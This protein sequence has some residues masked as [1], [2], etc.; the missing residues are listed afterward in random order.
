MTLLTTA[1]LAAVEAAIAAAESQS[2][3]ELVVAVVG[4]SDRY[5]LPRGLFA[6][7]STL[8]LV[9]VLHGLFPHVPATVLL[10]GQGPW[11]LLSWFVLGRP[12]F[13]RHLAGDA[14]IE[15]TV[16]QRALQMFAAHGVYRTRDQSGLL[17]M[18]SQMERRVIILGDTGI[19]AR[20][21]T[22]GWQGYIEI[23]VAG[24]RRGQTGPALVQVL[25]QLGA[26]L[27]EHFP[28]RPDD[29]NELPDR[30]ILEP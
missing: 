2:A 18:I 12:W 16:K 14:H 5:D 22:A 11:L 17:I 9:L 21:G 30:V 10:L 19:D 26:V 8:A 4:R 28:P 24:I 13:L 15:R 29:I 6:V 3:G 27:A 7:T 20:I 23:I 25:N 1:D